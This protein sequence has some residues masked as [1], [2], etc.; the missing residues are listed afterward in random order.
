MVVVLLTGVKR[1]SCC[2]SFG[3]G[4]M[5]CCLCSEKQK[6]GRDV[7]ENLKDWQSLDLDPHVQAV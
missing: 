5:Q 6:V 2:P 7:V 1:I 4:R 3:T